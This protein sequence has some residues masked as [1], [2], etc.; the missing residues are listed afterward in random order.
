MLKQV[1][2]TGVATRK[3]FHMQQILAVKGVRVEG[4]GEFAR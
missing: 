1:P 3:F 2:V 4:L